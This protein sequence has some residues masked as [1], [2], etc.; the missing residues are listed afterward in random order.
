MDKVRVFRQTQQIGGGGAGGGKDTEQDR[1]RDWHR[2]LIKI[3]TADKTEILIKLLYFPLYF[4]SKTDL[5][6][7]STKCFGRY[8]NQK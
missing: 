7:Y 3:S 4:L 5:P 1:A 2:Q 8:T 6:T